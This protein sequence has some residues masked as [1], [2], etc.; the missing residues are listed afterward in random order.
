VL[1]AVKSCRDG[2]AGDWREAFT[3]VGDQQ[4]RAAARLESEG[5]HV[6][7]GHARLGAACAYRSALHYTDPFGQSYNRVV[8]D[9]EDCF[10]AGA[11]LLRI[12]LRAVEVPFEGS[13]LS[14]YFLRQDDTRRPLLLMVGG[15]DTY[16]EDLISFAGFPG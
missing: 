11:R 1:L 15:G 7:A 5:V 10:Q 6:R 16:R 14:G 2:N 9:M 12:P 4:A 13:S 8:S 3:R